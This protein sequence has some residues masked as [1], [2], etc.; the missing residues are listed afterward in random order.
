[1]M[2]TLKEWSN[3]ER[4]AISLLKLSIHSFLSFF[5]GSTHVCQ[6]SWVHFVAFLYVVLSLFFLFFFFWM[7]GGPFSLLRVHLLLFDLAAHGVAVR[8]IAPL[9]AF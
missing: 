8:R 9:V 4:N 2:M 5:F 3:G 6:P 1:M 7:G